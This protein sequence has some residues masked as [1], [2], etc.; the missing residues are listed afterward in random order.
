MPPPLTGDGARGSSGKAPVVNL[1]SSSDEGDLIANISWDEAF[2]RRLYGDLN[3]DVVGPPNDGKII[4]LSDSDE[5]EGMREE[6]ATDVK[7][8][9]S[10]VVRSLASTASANDADGT[11]KSN[12]PDWATSG[13]SSG[14]D[15]VGLP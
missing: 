12:A 2:V 1:S 4:I 6:N 10:S 9:P 11:Y 7:A 15:K 8:A 5:E 13:C 14:G 3:C